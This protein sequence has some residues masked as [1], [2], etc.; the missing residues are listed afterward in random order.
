[1]VKSAFSTG[2]ALGVD[3]ELGVAAFESRR[4]ERADE[5]DGLFRNILQDLGGLYH[6]VGAVRDEY[7]AAGR[8]P[9]PLGDDGAVG[10]GQVEA[11]FAEE[12]L[13][14]VFDG[15]MG[16]FED[17]DDLRLAH[18]EDTPGV[19]VDLVDGAAGG[20]DLDVHTTLTVSL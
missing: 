3:V 14:G 12:H 5:H 15:D 13:D 17:L 16:S 1:M 7:T 2:I 19:E 11:V 20:E 4:S 9:H 18:L 6:R 10:I 8:R